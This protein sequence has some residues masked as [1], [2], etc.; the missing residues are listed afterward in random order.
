ME[1]GTAT[2]ADLPAEPDETIWECL[3]PTM[4]PL[5]CGKAF[6]LDPRGDL[7]LKVGGIVDGQA[8]EFLVC[9]R[10]IARFSPV[11]NSMLFGGFAESEPK[12]DAPWT[13]ELPEDRASPIFLVL[14]IVHGHFMKIPQAL[15]LEELYHLVVVTEKFDMTQVL[16][17]LAATWFQ[18]HKDSTSLEGIQFA[19]CIAWELG[20]EESFRHLSKV[21]LLESSVNDDGNLLDSNKT[22]VNLPAFM[23]PLG[24]LDGIAQA[25]QKLIQFITSLFNNVIRIMLEGRG[26]RANRA[27]PQTF[28]YGAQMVEFKPIDCCSM[29]LGQLIRNVERIGL[30]KVNLLQR[31]KSTYLGSVANLSS[32]IQNIPLEREGLHSDCN[33]LLIIKEK[34]LER[35]RDVSIPVQ[36]THLERLRNQ[37]KKTGILWKSLTGPGGG[38]PSRKRA[39]E[40]E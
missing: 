8:H 24:I 25:R 29:A 1:S 16:H 5:A 37:A 3:K 4:S 26:C 32:S 30:Q 14:S 31:T 38:E 36:D 12:S 9:S 33:Y 22:P 10:S 11:F 7:T 15:K 19:I 40:D 39:R 28:Y 23:E 13:V 27:Q 6:H 20:H 18:P 34:I 2:A 35:I 21:L 17:P